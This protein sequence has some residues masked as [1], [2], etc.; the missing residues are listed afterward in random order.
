MQ[1][2]YNT[3]KFKY[4]ISRKFLTQI[5]LNTLELNFVRILTNIQYPLN[6]KDEDT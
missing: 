4:I 1:D 6:Q 2:V 3:N 5:L